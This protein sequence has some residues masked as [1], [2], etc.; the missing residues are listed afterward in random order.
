[1]WRQ[2]HG[3]HACTL[4][5]QHACIQVSSIFWLHGHQTS[6]TT[7][8][9]AHTCSPGKRALQYVAPGCMV[10]TL[11]APPTHMPTPVHLASVR[12]GT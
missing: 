4:A 2:W 6:R 12:F 7:H 11:A 10:T 1:M 8:A 9:H 5:I 3:I